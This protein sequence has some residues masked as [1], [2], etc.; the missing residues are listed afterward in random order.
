VTT[1]A[2]APATDATGFGINVPDSWF[3]VDLQPDT[4]NNSINDLVTERLRE[5]PELYEHRAALSRALRSAARSA[6]AG[7]AVYCGTMVQGLG[8]AVLTATIT[9]SLVESPDENAGAEAI[10]RQLTAIAKGGPDTPWREVVSVELPHVGR[11]PRTQGVED[12]TMPE[13]SGWIRTVLMQTFVPVPGGQV[14]R[15]ALI[16][17]SSPILPLADE[18]LDLFDAVTSTFRFTTADPG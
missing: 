11:V 2:S 17:C 12:V 7:G 1:P 16:T 15:V 4:R 14:N 9:V 6:F 8:D 13:G 10:A 18:L 3:E 5:V